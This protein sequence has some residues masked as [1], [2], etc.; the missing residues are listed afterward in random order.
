[1]PKKFQRK[2]E[3]FKC[4]HC[5]KF[6]KGNGF[7]DHCPNCLWSKHVDLNPGD[8]QSFCRKMMEPVG[9]EV[10]G[11]S[12]VIYYKCTVCGYRHRVKSNSEDN[13][14]EILKLSNQPIK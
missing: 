4:E 13:L 3:N 7:T 12:Y 2:I 8:R 1:M 9:V 11:D 14:E 6:V 5:G 10:K